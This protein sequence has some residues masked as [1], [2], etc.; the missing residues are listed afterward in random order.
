MFKHTKRLILILALLLLSFTVQ[1]TVKGIEQLNSEQRFQEAYQLGQQL[2]GEAAGDPSFDM[3]F[4]V[5]A[6]RSGEYDQ[7]LFAFERV[8]M[9]NSKIQVARFELARTHFMLGNLMVARRHFNQLIE[10]DPQP[11]PAAMKRIQWHMAA[12]NAKESGKAV[13]NSDAATRLHLG[14]RLGYDSN[15][16]NMTHREVLLY[17]VIPFT[18][19]V[20]SDTYHE[21]YAGVV[22]YQQQ[23]EN[24]GWFVGADA[25]FRGY[26]DSKSDMDNYSLGLQAGGVLLGK[27]W[28]LSLPL[29]INKQVRE[30]KS[31]A[32]VLAMA[33]EFNQQLNA[34]AD[35]TA[36]G[37]LALVDYKPGS[38]RD[39]KSFTAGVIYSY[40]FND[41]LKVYGG[42][43][44][45]LENADSDV[46]SRN[47]YGARTGAGY[48]LNDRQKIDFNFSYLATSH[49]DADPTFLKKRKD[50]QLNMG[51]KFSQR[52]SD[53]WLVDLALQQSMHDSTLNL[54]SYNRTQLSVGIRKEW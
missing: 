11:P 16:S 50:D 30:D 45:G 2:L 27:N 9:Y 41:K 28:R 32:L 40:R 15:P 51:I 35:Y 4:G 44:F 1:A 49:K 52:Y 19:D 37:Q 47:L 53:D 8:L 36:F 7:A 10:A 39:A 38:T 29:Q 26:H 22:R 34:K 12:I 20:D 23:A 48:A 42:P 21:L 14:M 54:Y 5:A 24:W 31:E 46:Y 18:G 17:D 25:S 43:V 13:A 33:A 6:L 3:A